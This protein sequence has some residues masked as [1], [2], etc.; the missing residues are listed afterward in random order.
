MR[1]TGL[2]HRPTPDGVPLLADRANLGGAPKA[3]VDWYAKMAPCTDPLGNDELGDCFEAAALRS[4]QLRLANAMGSE[5]V[6]TRDEAVLLYRAWAGYNPADAATDVGTNGVEAMRKWCAN[7]VLV[8]PQLR[9]IP[10]WTKVDPGNLAHIKLAIEL[11]GS[12]QLSLN[13]PKVAME[14]SEWTMTPGVDPATAAGSEGAHRVMCGKFDADAY[15]IATWG[16]II[17]AS[18][19]FLESYLIAVD[20]VVA[21]DWFE[22][23]DMLSASGLNRTQLAGDMTLLAA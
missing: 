23:T 5:W 18:A 8:N 3:S 12:V 7:G 6:P 15:W 11:T 14:T 9:D 19:G 21:W 16:E 22:A 17:P 1:R 13:L 10:A 20:A 2:I 4:I